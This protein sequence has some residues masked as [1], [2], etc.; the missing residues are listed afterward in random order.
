MSTSV[1]RTEYL[2]R[3]FGGLL[4]VNDV[5]LEVRAGE[6]RALIG[7]NGAGKSTL[8]NLLAGNLM[9]DVGRILMDNDDVTRLAVHERARLGMSRSFQVVSLFADLTCREVL[10][11]AVQR[12]LSAKSWFCRSGR[13]EIRKLADAA[14]VS[15]G[16]QD[17]ADE[18]TNRISHGLQKH[19]E[20]ALALVGGARVLL[21]DEPMAGMSASERIDL[22]ERLR[23]LGSA[24]TV[25]FVEHDIEMVMSLAD[26]VTV[27][28]NGSVIADGSP[29]QVQADAAAQRAYLG[30]QH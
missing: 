19:L 13:Q 23:R 25:L 4:A 18:E 8:L 30:A 29:R 27:M 2:S 20:I 10:E 21:L 5:H 26:S 1:L 22:R 16:L 3:S 24:R 7:P 12:D 28:H 17:V 15:A 11:I 6:I 14:L 9:P